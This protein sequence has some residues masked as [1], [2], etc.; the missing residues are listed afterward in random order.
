MPDTKDFLLAEYEK[1]FDMVIN[2]DNR[3][4]VFS[5]YYA[6]LTSAIIGL[7]GTLIFANSD[8][9]NVE[10][11]LITGMLSIGIITGAL[12]LYVLFSERR[13]NIRYRKK[14]NLIRELLVETGTDLS[15]KYLDPR[16]ASIGIKTYT[17]QQKAQPKGIGST[18]KGIFLSIILM[19]AVQVV[20]IILVWVHATGAPGTTGP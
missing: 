12:T 5:R 2:I 3:R 8:V 6:A 1:S 7:S 4:G 14:I 18:L 9:S 10:A 19:Q 15:K 20:V 17:N 16:N 11:W 13:A